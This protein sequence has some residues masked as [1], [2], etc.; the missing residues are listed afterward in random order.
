MTTQ[1]SQLDPEVVNQLNELQGRV[2]NL[3]NTFGQLYVRRKI[4]REEYETLEQLEKESDT[5]YV[6]ANKQ[7]N[8]ILETLRTEYKNGS[9]DLQAGT[10]T[11]VIE[12]Q[13]DGDIQ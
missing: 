8:S 4:L 12:D 13:E 7:I 3:V 1:I 5:A 9:I 2:T 11:Y 6:D 10:V